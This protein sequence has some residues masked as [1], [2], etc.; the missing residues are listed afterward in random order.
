[1][2]SFTE[3]WQPEPELDLPAARRMERFCAAALDD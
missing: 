3:P 1:M 2:A